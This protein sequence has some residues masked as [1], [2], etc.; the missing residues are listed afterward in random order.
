MESLLLLLLLLL[1]LTLLSYPPRRPQ[2]PTASC[3]KQIA[4]AQ[5]TFIPRR[6]LSPSSA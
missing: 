4:T 6:T 3:M 1:L 5:S 2:V